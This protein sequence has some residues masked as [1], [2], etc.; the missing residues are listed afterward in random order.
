MGMYEAY[1]AVYDQSGQLAFGLRMV[2][3][4]QELLAEHPVPGRAMV[5]LACGTGTVAVAMAQAGWRVN[6]VDLSPAMLDVARA[7]ATAADVEIA[8]SQQDMRR[9]SVDAPVDLVTCLYDS[10]N[11]MLSSE[12]LLRTF[13]SVRAALVPGGAFYFDMNTAY[14]FECL[15]DDATYY[16]DGDDLCTVLSSGYDAYHQRTE[17]VVT[18]FRRV[19]ALYE[20]VQE[21]HVEQAY[22]PEQIATLLTDAGLRVEASYDCFHLTPPHDETMRILWVARREG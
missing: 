3:Y 13:C 14:A 7:K 22:P 9:L 6:G 15:W 20:K 16:T 21:R 17:V 8:W 5:E 1:A 18:C 4:L 2:P 12:D 19:G 10:M 11:Y